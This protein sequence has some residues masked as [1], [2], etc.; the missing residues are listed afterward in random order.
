[1]LGITT[2]PPTGFPLFQFLFSNL[3][4]RAEAVLPTP[5]FVFSVHA[6]LIFVTVVVDAAQGLKMTSHR[7]SLGR[8]SGRKLLQIASN[9]L[10][11]RRAV[12]KHLHQ[13]T[14]QQLRDAHTWQFARSLTTKLFWLIS[15]S[16]DDSFYFANLQCKP[17][18]LQVSTASEDESAQ[19]RWPSPTDFFFFNDK[20]CHCQT[21]FAP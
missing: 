4:L 17:I 18:F 3:R 6:C 20:N 7:D 8:A 15:A 9:W 1:V 2:P 16:S 19:T 14:A 21:V 13:T 12:K 5:G 11:S 10:S